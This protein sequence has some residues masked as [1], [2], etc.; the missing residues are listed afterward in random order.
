M[1]SKMVR[2]VCVVICIFMYFM[3][4]ALAGNSVY[5]DEK[6]NVFQ[7]STPEEAQKMPQIVNDLK[8]GI[9]AYNKKDYKEAIIRLTNAANAKNTQAMVVLG[10]CYQYGLG[11]DVDYQKAI[12]YY[13]EA[14]QGLPKQ[15]E[16]M[17][18]AGRLY[19]IQAVKSTSNDEKNKLIMAAKSW[20]EQ[21]SINEHAESQ[22]TLGEYY[23]GAWKRIL[24]TVDFE[25]IASHATSALWYMKA[26]GNGEVQAMLALGDMYVRGDGVPKDYDK[27]RE[28]FRKAAAKGNS[29]AQKFLKEMDKK[30]EDKKVDT[31]D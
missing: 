13:S 6:G 11:T 27:A 26:A 30:I 1:L 20:F 15:V 31:I 14:A 12:D 29:H 18:Y 4:N 8:N 17:N 22:T 28:F 24:P 10:I 9:E 16:A 23:Y 21:A 2:E 19:L 5:I 7:Y 25:N 3:S